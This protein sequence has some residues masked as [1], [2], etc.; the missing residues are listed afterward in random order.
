M[1]VQSR[2]AG[3]GNVNEQAGKPFEENEEPVKAPNHQPGGKPFDARRL[4]G[5]ELKTEGD[6]LNSGAEFFHEEKDTGTGLKY[7]INKYTPGPVFTNSSSLLL[8][9]MACRLKL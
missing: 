8:S 7:T 9:L 2:H 6:N 4:K 1:T 5:F 3:S